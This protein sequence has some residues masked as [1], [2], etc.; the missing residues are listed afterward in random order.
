M[1]ELHTHHADKQTHSL[2]CDTDSIQLGNSNLKH[3]S[4]FDALHYYLDPHVIGSFY[5]LLVFI[6][7]ERE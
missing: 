4:Y 1:P 7:T 3:V 6:A 2:K 5:F